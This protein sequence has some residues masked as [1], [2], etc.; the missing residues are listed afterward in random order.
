MET[1]VIKCDSNTAMLNKNIPQ[2]VIDILSCLPKNR[3][4]PLILFFNIKTIKNAQIIEGND[5]TMNHL[6]MTTK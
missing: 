4:A 3:Q 6:L 2:E 5:N 1:T